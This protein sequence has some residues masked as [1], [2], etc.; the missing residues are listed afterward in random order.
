MRSL[1]LV[2]S[3]ALAAGVLLS[4][5]GSPGT[6]AG[7]PADA[8][9]SA[10]VPSG[11]PPKPYQV[12][13]GRSEVTENPDGTRT[14][15]SS[16][17][18]ATVPA[19]PARIV[20]ILGYVDFETMLALGVKPVGAGTQGGPAASGFAP[21]L[22]ALTAGIEPLDWSQGA[23]V[24]KI[25]ALRPDLIFAPDQDSYKAVKDLAPTVAA[26][27]ADSRTWKDDA[28]YVGAVLGRA[29]QAEGLI[30]AYETRAADLSTKLQPVMTGK[31]VASPQ[32]THDRSQVTVSGANA[33]ASTVMR[34]AGLT[35]APVLKGSDDQLALS[36]ENL[37]DLNAD[38]LFWQVRQDDKG[39]RDVAALDIVTK[40]PLWS[41]LPAVRADQVHQVDNRPWYFPTILSAGQ[42]LTDIDKALL[43]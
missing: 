20:T 2:A 26:G 18:T 31:T 12:V 1:R 9:S 33:F 34:E 11:L 42:M 16:W 8:A 15:K 3:A 32:V 7:A 43:G 38:V 30:A 5:C 14:V 41:K 29:G 25:A 13:E 10:V 22:S 28:R 35:L 17:G 19:K 27:A 36:F 40:S 21:H 4:G 24:E 23:P 37:A 39:A 6:T